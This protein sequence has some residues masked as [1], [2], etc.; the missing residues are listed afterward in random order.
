MAVLDILHYPD[1]RLRAQAEPVA[2]V[3][4]GIRSLVDDM[5]ET[6]YASQGVGLAAPQVDRHLRLLVMDTSEE[7]DAPLALINPEIVAAEGEQDGEEGCLSLPGVYEPVVR[8]AEVTA[9]FRDRE[10]RER[11]ERF[12][13]LAARCVQHEL[14][15]LDGKLFVDY[16]SKLKRSRV[17]K[18][19]EKDKRLQATPA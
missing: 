19:M 12:S 4:D 10:G 1:D 17:R 13:G 11:E 3:D 9:R 5:L 6:M 2:E 16:L 18:K 7:R 8:A 15:H 14:D